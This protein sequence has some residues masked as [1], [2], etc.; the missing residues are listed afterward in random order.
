MKHIALLVVGL[1]VFGCAEE[2]ATPS[3]LGDSN[4]KV[5]S[6]KHEFV[7]GSTKIY[8]A[9]EYSGFTISFTTDGKFSQT[10]YPYTFTRMGKWE[11][12]KTGKLLLN[13]LNNDWIADYDVIS[14]T[15]DKLILYNDTLLQGQGGLV[16]V[17]LELRPE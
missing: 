4:W 7:D 15:D 8:A 2:V 16:K 1:F 11:H 13:D 12:S 10:L 9:D 6:T 14:L 5:F 3:L 17:T